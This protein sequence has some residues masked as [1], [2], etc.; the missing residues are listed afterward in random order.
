MVARFEAMVQKNAKTGWERR[1]RCA[2]KDEDD[3]GRRCEDIFVYYH[4]KSI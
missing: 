1:L 4:L 2:V 3:E